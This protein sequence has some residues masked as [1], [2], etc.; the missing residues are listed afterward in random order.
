MLDRMTH[1]CLA[2]AVI[3]WQVCRMYYAEKKAALEKREKTIAAN[4]KVLKQVQAKSEQVLQKSNISSTIQ[5]MRKVHWFEKFNWFITSE[6]YLV[7]SGRDMQQSELL[8]KR[9]GPHSPLWGPHLNLVERR[10][11]TYQNWASRC[12]SSTTNLHLILVRR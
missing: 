6:G 1:L 8:L 3:E 2:V 7:L 9:C 5:A 11:M 12:T 4:G 10:K